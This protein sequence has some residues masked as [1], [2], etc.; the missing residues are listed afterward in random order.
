MHVIKYLA[1]Y[2]NQMETYKESVNP[3]TRGPK[4]L[5]LIMH[6]AILTS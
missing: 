1:W 6:I 5:K 3:E 4:G 2:S